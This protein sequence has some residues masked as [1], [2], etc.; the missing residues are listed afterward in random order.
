VSGGSNVTLFDVDSINS[1]GGCL[2][3][4]NTTTLRVTNIYVS[5]C[6]ADGIFNNNVNN[7][8]EANL[9]VDSTGDDGL[10][11]HNLSGFPQYSNG[12]FS[13]L[14]LT[15][16][17]GK[18]ISCDGCRDVV[19][20]GF[21]IRNTAVQ[22]VQI[23]SDRYAGGYVPDNVTLESG[24]ISS[25]GTGVEYSSRGVL[26]GNPHGI[27]VNRARRVY[28][29]GI[30]IDDVHT[31]GE[32]AGRGLNAG[33]D[34]LILSLADLTVYDVADVGVAIGPSAFSSLSN[35]LVRET[36]AQG[37]SILNSKA[38]VFSNLA[39]VNASKTSPLKRAVD[40]E[41][42]TSIQGFGVSII[43]MQETATGTGY[44]ENNNGAGQ[45]EGIS[46]VLFDRRAAPVQVKSPT[47]KY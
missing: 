7:A 10:A 34:S 25:T 8:V 45:I 23:Y 43:D 9:R 44:F 46:T 38:V 37:I 28:I 35:I 2:Q 5:G 41:R 26:V 14:V 47:V 40:L 18:G 19:V 11:I 36:G 33:D 1:P 39:V 15:N 30:T 24:T 29:R 6:W 20:H 32:V 16:I 42:N 4:E 12:T 13:N 27:E 31:L 17:G 3:F 22:G 21:V